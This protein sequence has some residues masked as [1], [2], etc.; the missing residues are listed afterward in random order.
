MSRIKR[1]FRKTMSRAEIVYRNPGELDDMENKSMRI[2]LDSDQIKHLVKDI[3]DLFGY[4][5]N[6]LNGSYTDYSRTAVLKA[7]GAI[8]YLLW[9]ADAIPDYI[10]VAGFA[11]DATVIAYI[12]GE[13]RVE[14]ER[15]R[16]WACA[17]VQ[18]KI[19]KG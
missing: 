17:A 14:I 5:R 19:K 10:P 12:L 16:S 15:Y 13:I 18:N 1:I 2:A 8:I 3:R 7:I 11:D 9:P 6:A 4:I